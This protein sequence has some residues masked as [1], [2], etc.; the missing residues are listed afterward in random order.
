MMERH[1][2]Y[3]GRLQMVDASEDFK[4]E[5]RLIKSGKVSA[6]EYRYSLDEFA[7]VIH[8]LVDAYNAAP[9]G[10]HLKGLCP[11]EAF[12][13]LKDRFNPPKKIDSRLHW[14]LA[15]TRNR[16]RVTAG[17]VTFRRYGQKIQVRGQ[18]LTP[19]IGHELWALV[20]REDDSL[21]TFMSLDY[22]DTFTMEICQKPSADA[23]RIATGGSV[24]ARELAKIGEHAKAVNDEYKALQAE[25]GNPR[26]DLLAQMR[27]ET[28]ALAGA[29][30]ETTR[31]IILN[32]RLEKAG[33][34]IAAQRAA[35]KQQR[36][37]NTVTKS[38]ASRMGAPSVLVRNDDRFRRAIELDEEAAREASRL[39]AT[40]ETEP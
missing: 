2:G 21:V 6:S 32:T 33:D 5:Q 28:P 29:V 1:P 40:E 36:R 24:L 37:Q 31:R 19:H 8:R 27:S 4:R 22:S 26:R 25:F 20:D 39:E 38:K 34:D 17:G 16:V 23:S 13:L 12:E 3:G 11:N 30:E 14:Y 7:R 35:I 9:Q 15:N 10:G 18:E